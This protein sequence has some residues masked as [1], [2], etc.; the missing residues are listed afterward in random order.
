MDLIANIL[1]LLPEKTDM[2][3]IQI[4]RKKELKSID[5]LIIIKNHKKKTMVLSHF[6]STL[7]HRQKKKAYH[8][9]N[10]KNKKQKRERKDPKYIAFN[11]FLAA[12]ME[13]NEISKN[14]CKSYR[15]YRTGSL[16]IPK[17]KIH[18]AK[19]QP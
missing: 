17:R 1:I 18:P 5:L 12:E 13:N 19:K 11:N 3:P 7:K 4:I 8:F 9:L 10:I 6:Q 16:I 2:N 14:P 15:N